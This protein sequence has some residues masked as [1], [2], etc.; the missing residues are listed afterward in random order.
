MSQ[1][2]IS[3]IT[4]NYNGITDTVKM[5]ESVILN[6]KQS[7]E[8]IVVDNG[9]VNDET[10]QLKEK[11]P[12]VKAIR[13]SKNLGFAGGN[14]LGYRYST[15]KHLL[16]LNNDTII[17]DDSVQFLLESIKKNS[18]IAGG[19]PKILFNDE[20]GHI[21]FAGYSELSRI[22][23]RN[24]T[25]GYDEKDF[26]QHETTTHTAYLHG[27]AMLV[28]REVIEEVG[29]MPDCYFL[30]YEEMDWS[31]QIKNAGYEL[32]YEP[33]TKVYHNE[34]SSTGKDSPLKIYYMSRNRLLFAWRN[35][36]GLTKI[37][38]VAYL[39]LILTSKNIVKFTV[40]LRFDLIKASFKGFVDFFRIITLQKRTL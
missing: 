27:A 35:R 39:V 6:L 2:E 12:F 4:V 17:K 1:P 3:I 30:Y 7:F 8:I 26:G 21:Q 11:Y 38:S 28:K 25:I 37:I 19:S 14:N 29:L 10:L 16:F 40:E 5:I 23:I 32:I 24:K 22:T 34:S 15:G 36:I 33:R 9:S 13:S 18:Q 31:A 20:H